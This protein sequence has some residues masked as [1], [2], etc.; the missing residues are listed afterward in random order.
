MPN[1]YSNPDVILPGLVDGSHQVQTLW[2]DDGMVLAICAV[3]NYWG[4]CWNGFFLISQDFPP[5]AIRTLRIA[6][7]NGMI[8]NNALR[9][10][11]ESVSNHTIRAWHKLLGFEL[12]GVRKKMMFDRDYDMW[13][14]MREGA[15]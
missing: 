7:N 3:R 15:K 1:E 13:A 6:I 14:L 5:A 8:A 2:G 9:L 4:Q 11:T 10:Q 12:E